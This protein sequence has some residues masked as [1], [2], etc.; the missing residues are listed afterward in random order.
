MGIRT[1][2]REIKSD[3]PLYNT[4]KTYQETQF[5][6]L[7]DKY[8]DV[9]CDDD[10]LFM[11]P[12]GDNDT[13]DKFSLRTLPRL[14]EKKF[15]LLKKIDSC[16]VTPKEHIQLD[17]FFAP[18]S[19]NDKFEFTFSDQPAKKYDKIIIKNCLQFFDKYQKYFCAF[20]YSMLKN[21]KPIVPCLLI[22]QRVNDVST[23]PFHQQV[24]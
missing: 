22:I 18:V 1:A 20:I 23:L 10:I 6:H 15:C 19:L 17:R 7:I 3:N 2:S 24:I 14:I 11:T 13:D 5:N 12:L 9:D 16:E 4:N 21:V 8:L